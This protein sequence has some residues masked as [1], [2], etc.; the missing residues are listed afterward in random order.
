MLTYRAYICKMSCSTALTFL[1]LI[2]NTIQPERVGIIHLYSIQKINEKKKSQITCMLCDQV[3]C[4]FMQNIFAAHA[5]VCWLV[6]N[7]S[8]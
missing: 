6:S 7:G 4:N 5:K 3:Y 2:T 1:M 8:T